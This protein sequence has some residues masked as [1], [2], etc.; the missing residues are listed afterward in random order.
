MV[1]E[2]AASQSLKTQ[3]A[4]K[5][6]QNNEEEEEPET[7]GLVRASGFRNLPS[8]LHINKSDL[9]STPSLNSS[10]EEKT[11]LPHSH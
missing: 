9:S 4:T 8:F 10:L 11:T 1:F 7:T 6:E 5:N 3:K 2:R